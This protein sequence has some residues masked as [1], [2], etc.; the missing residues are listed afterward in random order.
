MAC[1][2]SSIKEPFDS[3]CPQVLNLIEDFGIGE[4][5]KDVSSDDSGTLLSH[6]A[7]PA[8]LTHA[9][10]DA[11]DGESEQRKIKKLVKLGQEIKL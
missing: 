5:K 7:H 4:Q 10:S 6:H 11:S 9:H 3:C 8:S 1:H 2:I